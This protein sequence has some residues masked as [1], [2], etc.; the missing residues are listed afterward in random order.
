MSATIRD[1]LSSD[2]DQLLLHEVFTTY[3]NKCKKH[4][5]APLRG[6]GKVTEKANKQKW[7]DKAEAA[8]QLLS[9]LMNALI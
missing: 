7:A 3:I 5:S 6:Y 9:T 2:E 1:L 8:D 4:A